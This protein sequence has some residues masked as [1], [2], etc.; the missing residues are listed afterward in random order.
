MA[1]LRF[2][3][4]LPA[5]YYLDTIWH[6]YSGKFTSILESSGKIHCITSLNIFLAVQPNLLLSHNKKK[7]SRNVI[8]SALLLNTKHYSADSLFKQQS[9][10]LMGLGQPRSISAWLVKVLCHG[11]VFTVA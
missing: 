6:L 8:D 1:D 2:F 3:I 7:H 11:A 10:S 5:Q 4:V 9:C